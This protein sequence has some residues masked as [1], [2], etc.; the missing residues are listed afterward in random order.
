M[1]RGI[2]TIISLSALLWASGW[3]DAGQ[4]RNQAWGQ[5][6]PT[7]HLTG[8]SQKTGKINLAG[9][10][11]EHL[12]FTV[13]LANGSPPIK[14][15][16]DGTP[17][18][19]E[20]NFFRVVAV[21]SASAGKFPPDG[22]LP[23]EEDISDSASTPLTLWISIKISPNRAAGLYH[24]VLVVTDRQ[25]SIRLPIELR[26]YRFSLPDD[27]PIT[28]F[29]GFWP[30]PGLWP[31]SAE[32]LPSME[33]IKHYFQS[34]R[35]HKFNAL[36]GSYPLPLGRI[37]AGQRIEDFPTYHELLR[38][39]LDDLKFK[40]FQI[41]KLKGWQSVSDTDST[42]SRQARI[43]YPLYSDYLRRH[44]WENRAL[45]YLVDEPRPPQYKSVF[46]AYSLAKSLAPGMRTLSAGWQ[47]SPEFVKVIDIWAYQAAHYRD[48]EK[49]RAQRQGQEAWL[50]ANRLQDIDHPLTHLRLIG[51]LLYR[52]HFS[53]YLL[54]GVNYWPNN[55]WTTPPGPQD[56]S[57]RGTL[58][59]PHPRTGLPVS[60]T[61][62]ESLRRGLQDYQYLLL[63]DQACRRGL[64][65]KEQ[66]AFILAKV[67]S[68]TANLS[69]NPFPV[70]MDE[71][72][73]LRRH[74]GELLD[75]MDGKETVQGPTTPSTRL[76]NN[77]H[78]SMEARV[79]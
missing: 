2:L 11:N 60:T 39:A 42:F 32:G 38:Y 46:Q 40:Y 66:R 7:L 1:L 23:L 4:F 54:W 27:L 55:P 20:C 26:V 53:G 76:L 57:R 37:Q 61:R 35:E 79:W 49:K 67:D 36:G 43:F 74:I 48:D 68:I 62:L 31:K 14:A 3:G 9:A 21:P 78:H 17:E 18:G 6:A 50:Y 65:R 13:S 10:R 15:R 12:F 73:A 24:L 30:Q 5:P 58:Y 41:P 69:R 44:G 75:G 34:L 47:P 16:M 63:L 71:L 72:E 56:Y 51:W 52:Y 33:I 25:G 22:L 19:L 59:Y 77:S 45:N 29:G 64:I 28:I 8:G 70:S